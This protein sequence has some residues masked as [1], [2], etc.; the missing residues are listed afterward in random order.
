MKTD[1]IRLILIIAALLI[2]I[3]ALIVGSVAVGR[4]NKHFPEDKAKGDGQASKF[5]RR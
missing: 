4:L 2:A 1:T 3:I 5:H